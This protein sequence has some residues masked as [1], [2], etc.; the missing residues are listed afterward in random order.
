MEFKNMFNLTDRTAIITG[1]ASGIGKELALTLANA[2]ANIILID[3]DYIS[4]MKIESLIKGKFEN[5]EVY[6]YECDVSNEI[7][8]ENTFNSIAKKVKKIDICFSNAGITEPELFAGTN[9]LEYDFKTWKKVLETNLDGTFLTCKAVSKFMIKQRF[10][11][12]INISSIF[13]IIGD[14]AGKIGYS[15]SKGGIQQITR[16]LAISLGPYN[17][18][19]NNIA[20]G[21]IQTDMIK[22][23]REKITK[24][25]YSDIIRKTPLRRL[26]LAEDIRGIALFLASDAS[27][28]CTGS[29]FIID[30]GWLA[31]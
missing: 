15:A 24:T 18:R 27:S 11:S 31:Q 5:I 19:V 29:T 2:G 17:I 23:E 6:S 8:I 9:I 12:I 21:F 20:P 28:F 7:Q 13:G 30:G 16:S 1:A 26:G 22:D 25:V 14:Y 10:G 4:L 3:I